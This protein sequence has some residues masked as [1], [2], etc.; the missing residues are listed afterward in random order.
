MSLKYKSALLGLVVIISIVVAVIITN[1]NSKVWGL[2]DYNSQKLDWQDCYGEFQCSSFKVPIDYDNMNDKNFILQV[3]KHNA[4]DEASKLGAIVVN[5]GGPGGSAVHYAFNAKYIVSEGLLKKYDIV[6]F[7]SRGINNSEEIRCLTDAEEDTFLSADASDGKPQSIAD[8]EA[9]SKDFAAKCAKSAGARLGHVSTLEAAKDMEILR[10]L[11]NEDKLNYLGKS[12]GTYLG[13]LYASLFPK[14]V[15]RMV[16][17]GAVDPSSTLREQQIAQAVGFDRALNNYLASQSTFSLVEIQTLLMNSKTSPMEDSSGRK[18]T[19]SLVITA[20]AQSLY[21]SNEGWRELSQLLDKAIIKDDPSGIFELADRYNTRGESGS[22]YS[23]Q[24]DIAIMITCLDWKEPRTVE[25]M[26]S[27]RDAFIKA[28]P[29]FGQFLNFA[30]LPC[31]YWK[32]KPQLP[33]TQLTEIDT[34]PIIIIG[35]TEDPATPYLWSQNLAKVFTNSKLLTLRGEGHTGHN[36]GNKCVDS[37]VDSY[38]LTGKI[39]AS[40]LI[41]A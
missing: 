11:L 5:P 7:D 20:I 17:D 30:G 19:Q 37:A 1:N 39:R 16:L 14:S 36:Q 28:A 29:V 10:I 18:A 40:A 34:S 26:G 35:V 4:L 23:N 24:N 13:T 22:Y 33:E 9:I 8:L 27:D 21:D 31:K 2:N 32:A 41:C 6:G 15:G 38:Y 3:L 25:Q 12:Y